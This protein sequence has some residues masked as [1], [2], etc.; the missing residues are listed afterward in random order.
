MVRPSTVAN[1]L[2]NDNVSQKTMTGPSWSAKE[3]TGVQRTHRPPT[4]YVD[5]FAHLTVQCLRFGFDVVSGYL[6][7]KSFGAMREPDWIRRIIFLE[8][9]AGVPGMVAGMLRH[10]HSLRL[11]RRDYGW[12]HT[13]LAEAE[14]ERMHLLIALKLR[15]PGPFFRFFVIV[16]QCGFLA[17]YTLAY[18]I[19]P[20]YCHRFVG[21]LEEEAVHTYS[22]LLDQIDNGT[23]PMFEQMKAPKF[24]AEYYKLDK[25]ATL[26]DVFECIRMDESSHRDTN[27]HLGDLK[28]TEPNLMVDHL[29]K[30]HFSSHHVHQATTAVAWKLKE[31]TL[32]KEFQILDKNQ[33]GVLTLKELRRAEI[34]Q[35]LDLDED[36][37]LKLFSDLDQ[38]SDDE[39][40]L[41]EFMAVMRK[42]GG[43][44]GSLE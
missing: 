1:L 37:L 41:E 8:T 13:L 2:H 22:T 6:V 40:S 34:F 29:S 14:N 36:E 19:C 30:H 17:F 20:R 35:Q 21:Y 15:Q 26:R 33:D 12:I 28:P 5:R 3:L 27:H 16:G 24:A 25:E 7:K 42:L 10:L 11:M 23:L 44:D 38:N 32:R 43:F 9:V 31:A 4:D 39:V 18:L